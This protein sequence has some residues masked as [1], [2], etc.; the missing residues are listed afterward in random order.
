LRRYARVRDEGNNQITLTVKIVDSTSAIDGVREAETI[1]TN[2]DE[3]I[4]LL[5]L[6]GWQASAYQ[7]THR[8]L[9]QKDN[10]QIMIDEWPGV[11]PFIEIE[12][13]NKEDVIKTAQSLGFDWTDAIFGT[14]DQVFKAY[15]Q[16]DCNWVNFVPKITFD[17][18]LTKDMAELYKHHAS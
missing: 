15:W 8:E 13:D 11:P 10:V 3:G 12:S 5:T 16:E 9:W 14:V 17:T 7:E 18:P 4:K 2:F 1:I 6:L